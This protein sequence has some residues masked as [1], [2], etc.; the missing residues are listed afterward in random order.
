M[1]AK[2]CGSLMLLPAAKSFSSQLG[3]AL[4]KGVGNIFETAGET[5]QKRKEQEQ[6]DEAIERVRKSK[7]NKDIRNEFD[8]EEETPS[9]DYAE[10]QR[11]LIKGG[12]KEEAKIVA[13]EAKLAARSGEIKKKEHYKAVEPIF[14][15]ASELA[16]SLPYKKLALDEMKQA[17]EEGNLSFFSADNLAEITGIE[18][19]RSS[20][21][22]KFK[23]AAKEFFL[24]NTSRVGA[25]GLN[26]W[27]EK[28]IA[29]M[30]PQI[31]RS[32][33]ANLEVAELLA[34][35]NDVS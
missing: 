14:K 15:R 18:G 28:Q 34:M 12:R 1:S 35:E 32:Q 27:F 11:L 19:F 2:N 26:Q 20:S 6:L 30:Q 29:T 8:L 25:K 5:Y 4:G 7:T 22:A 3:E 24:S 23:T 9:R 21:G 33:Q 10:E 16:T 17:I 31:G 13:D